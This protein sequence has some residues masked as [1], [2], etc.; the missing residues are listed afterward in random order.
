[1]KEIERVINALCDEE[2][3]LLYESRIKSMIYAKPDI[4]T[5][6]LMG[7]DKPWVIQEKEY[8]L[9]NNDKE[10]FIF[11]AGFRGK[12]GL[13]LL[14]CTGYGH[15]VR[16]FIDNNKNLW[17]KEIL[18]KKVFEPE[19]M[20]QNTDCNVVISADQFYARDMYFQMAQMLGY[21]RENTFLPRRGYIRATYGNIYFDE[22]DARSNEVFMDCGAYDGETSAAFAKWADNNYE[23]IYAFEPSK[24]G[25]MFYDKT[26]KKFNLDNTIF[27]QKG[28]WDGDGYLDFLE[29]G[30]A[31]LIVESGGTDN[32]VAVTSIDNVLSG[33]KATFIKMDI[34]GAELKA[35]I[36]AKNT[37]LK[38]RPRLAISLYHKP[39]DIIEIPNYILDL[40]P[41]YNLKIRQY[42][43]DGVD[44]VL[45]AF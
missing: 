12:L 20:L 43:P 2:S 28:L 14:E 13:K 40:V 5:D 1:M 33:E 30:T 27:I 6:T 17:G 37:I 22:F 24:T 7:L 4:F 34:E 23:H 42:N 41:D 38:Y 21:P 36:G 19:Y 15:R 29:Q 31:S 18:G 35:L 10:L 26:V 8:F 25:K 32:T 16:G 39:Q 45:Y 3:V 9:D 44:C 11:G